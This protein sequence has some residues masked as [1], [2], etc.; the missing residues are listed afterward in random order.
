MSSVYGENKQKEIALRVYAGEKKAALAREYNISSRSIGR[1][2]DKWKSEITGNTPI[3]T[4][5]VEEQEETIAPLQEDDVF[6]FHVTPVS[7]ILFKTGETAES[8]EVCHEQKED[9]E[10]VVTACK[11]YMDTNDVSVL[12]EVFD[13]FHTPTRIENITRGRVT[14]DINNNTLTIRSRDNSGDRQLSGRLVD[15]IV[16]AA[17][18]GDDK[19]E[20]L[21]HF[22]DRLSFNTSSRAINELY[23]FLEAAD[24]E[25]DEDGQLICF[26][27]VR[28]DCTDVQSG[29]FDNSPGKVVWM[30]RG[31][32]DDDSSRTCSHGL[33]VCS[34]SYLPYFGGERVIR[35]RVCPSNVV[36][37]PID[38]YGKENGQVKAKRPTS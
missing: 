28:D 5:E 37:V 19:L 27:R 12:R 6:S 25:I 35:V 24:I 11:I 1:Y 33:H 17:L 18:E 9:Y 21:M 8:V 2:Y 26:K 16:Q 32:V 10:L 29:T 36:S 22:T 3:A 20:N 7:V 4:V 14:V 31:N 34:K 30:E 13:E 23:D 15:R 38:Y